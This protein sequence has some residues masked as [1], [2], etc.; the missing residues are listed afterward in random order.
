MAKSVTVIPANQIK[1]SYEDTKKEIRVAAYCRVSTEQEEQLGSFENQI[2]YYTEL[3]KNNPDWVMAGIFSDE[4]I[5]GTGT[6]KRQGFQNL[7]KACREG[8]VDRVITKSIS[9]FA[10]NTADC[11][12]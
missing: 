7:I 4:G 6:K 2:S 12:H 9:R 1:N 10:R 5:S 8:K 11:L 3:I